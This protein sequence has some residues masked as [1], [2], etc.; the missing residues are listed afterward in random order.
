MDRWIASRRCH[1]FDAM[2]PGFY[3]LLLS[4]VKSSLVPMCLSAEVQADLQVSSYTIPT[5]SN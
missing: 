2:G 3:F 1:G 5:A 4:T